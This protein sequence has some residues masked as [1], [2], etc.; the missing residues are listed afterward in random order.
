MAW[1]LGGGRVEE[2]RAWGRAWRPLANARYRVFF[3][4]CMAVWWC[5]SCGV[6]PPRRRGWWRARGGCV[7]RGGP[8]RGLRGRDHPPRP[9]P[10]CRTA[11]RGGRGREGGKVGKGKEGR[12]ARA[13]LGRRWRRAAASPPPPPP[14]R[15]R[16][17]R[18]PIRPPTSPAVAPLRAHWRDAARRAARNHRGD[19]SGGAGA[20]TGGGRVPYMIP[21]SP[22]PPGPRRPPRPLSP[23]SRQAGTAA[24]GTTGARW[25]PQHAAA[26]SRPAGRCGHS[27]ASRGRLV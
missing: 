11:K 21:P 4:L 3:S 9:A 16:A 27:A 5:L 23:S 7:G 20:A 18:P 19:G 1:G 26:T 25:Q 14:T 8:P 12:R 22:L 13:R 2:R 6:G 10:A 17:D 15:P 24:G